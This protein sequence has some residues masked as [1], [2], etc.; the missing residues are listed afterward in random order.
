VIIVMNNLLKWHYW[1]LKNINIDYRFN[2]YIA[3]EIEGT[4]HNLF[5]SNRNETA[6]KPSMDI[7]SKFKTTDS[8]L[9]ADFVFVPHPWISIKKNNSYLKYLTYLSQTTPLLIVNTD[10]NSPICK[11]PNTLEIRT[12]LHPRESEFR[13]IIVPYPAKGK[14]FQIRKWKP[15]PSI[16]FIGYVPKFSFGT[17]TSKSPYFISA[18]IKSSVY[19]NRR[20]SISKLR[21]LGEEFNV[22]CIERKSFTPIISNPNM[23]EHMKFYQKNLSISD[24]ILCP[25]GFA[26]TSIRFYETISSGA[27]PILVQSGSKFPM[28]DDNNF[29]TKNMLSVDLF[30]NWAKVISQDWAFLGESDNFYKRQLQNHLMFSESLDLQKYLEK[31]FSE[32]LQ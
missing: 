4:K 10:D 27:S 15:K 7:V 19:L 22:T 24:Y 8:H 1:S 16:S 30:S 29:W 11:L 6:F 12:F 14:D 20:I 23:L 31:L 26:N 9:N 17:L 3:D 21:R 13:K 32:Y 5:Y 2:L 18:P 25:R 28:L